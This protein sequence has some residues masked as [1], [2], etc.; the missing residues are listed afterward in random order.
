[1]TALVLPRCPF[2]ICYQ[3]GRPNYG[4]TPMIL[5]TLMRMPTPNPNFEKSIGIIR[6]EYED[7]IIP[8]DKN[9][10][11]FNAKGVVA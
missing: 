11:V 5:K 7:F 6:R 10:N 9:I 1:M 8:R 4:R 3:E 2:P